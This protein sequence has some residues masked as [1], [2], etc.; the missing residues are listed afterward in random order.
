MRFRDIHKESWYVKK[1]GKPGDDEDDVDCLQVEERHAA[2][3][4]MKG[5]KTKI[6]FL[7]VRCSGKAAGRISRYFENS[8]FIDL[9][10]LL[11]SSTASIDRD[12]VTYRYFAMIHRDEILAEQYLVL[13]FTIR[14]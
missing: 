10:G 2:K 8:A 9:L 13:L 4:M 5:V 6:F 12:F 1:S 3:V 7:I 14:R 11:F